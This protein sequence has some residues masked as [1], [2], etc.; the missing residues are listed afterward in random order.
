VFEDKTKQ[1]AGNEKTD[2][3]RS[4]D[5]A[6]LPPPPPHDPIEPDPMNPIPV[7]PPD[8]EP[9]PAERPDLDWAEHED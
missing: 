7:P 6:D 2:P 5:K 8:T 1:G 3:H 9:R 4:G